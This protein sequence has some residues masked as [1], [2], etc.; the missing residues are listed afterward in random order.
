MNKIIEVALTSKFGADAVTNL[1]EVIGATC[2]PEMATEILLGVYEKPEIPNTIFENGTKKTVVS[3]DYWDGNVRYAYEEKVT[4]HIYVD[5]NLDTSILTLENYLEY[6]K[7][8]EDA[9][10][11]SFRL[12]TGET[13][14]MQANTSITNWLYEAAKDDAL[15][16]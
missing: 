15:A 9:D 2:N 10:R 11:K 12:L 4:K 16:V 14:T 7:Q 5:T 6:E 3:V 13:K 8:Y 1:M